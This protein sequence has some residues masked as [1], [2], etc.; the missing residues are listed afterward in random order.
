MERLEDDNDVEYLQRISVPPELEDWYAKLMM[1]SEEE[2]IKEL[3]SLNA[4]IEGS[5]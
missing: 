4:T 1:M 2:Q 5:N 3:N